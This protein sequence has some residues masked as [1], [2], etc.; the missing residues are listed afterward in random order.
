ME[1]RYKHRYANLET[2]TDPISMLY[3]YKNITYHQTGNK[4]YKNI[5][6]K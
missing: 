3:M 4:K 2:K 1:H 5:V 6:I